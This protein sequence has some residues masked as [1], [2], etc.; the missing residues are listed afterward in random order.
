MSDPH[1]SSASISMPTAGRDEGSVLERAGAAVGA[2][3]RLGLGRLRSIELAWVALLGLGLAL[4]TGF[5]ERRSGSF[6]A[7]DRTLGVVFRWL[8]PLESFAVVGLVLGR[9]RLGE[10]VWCLARHGHARRDLATGLQ[11]SAMVVA[12]L[13]AVAT[14]VLALATAYSSLAGLGRDLATSGW[15]AALGAAAY[16][17][18]FAFGAT[19]LRFG[20]GRWLALHGDF[21]LGGSAGWWSVPWPRSHLRNLIGAEPPLGLAQASSSVLLAAMVVVL[22]LLGSLRSGD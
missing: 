15:I 13:L 21:V 12:A 8:V 5:I 9:G 18:W 3:A 22:A 17:A 4:A 2:G 19:A 20:R 1:P 16:V 10:G 11:L 7:P 6:G 14:T